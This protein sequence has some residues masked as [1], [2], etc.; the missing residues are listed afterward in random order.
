[1]EA[2]SM[3]A[4]L[5]TMEQATSSSSKSEAL[6][7]QLRA[8]ARVSFDA[9]ETFAALESELR[10]TATSTAQARV[11]ARKTTTFRS[12]R[13]AQ[14]YPNFRTLPRTDDSAALKADAARKNDA[15]RTPYSAPSDHR[16]R[17]DSPPSSW[18]ATDK[19]D[20]VAKFTLPSN[21]DVRRRAALDQEGFFGPAQG[22]DLL[23]VS[24]RFQQTFDQRQRQQ[25]QTPP[26][27]VRPYARACFSSVT[28]D[29]F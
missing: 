19:T 4:R 12:P 14:I 3:R 1:M 6:E 16:F 7:A 13:A 20:F 2:T 25:C 23:P 11:I 29:S 10:A 17:I 21:Q 27:P 26:Q 5:H 22:E 8:S 18:I 28:S 15:I 9:F 24:I